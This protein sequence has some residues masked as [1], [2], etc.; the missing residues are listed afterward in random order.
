MATG[1]PIVLKPEDTKVRFDAE[2]AAETAF[3]F[4][5]SENV[6]SRFAERVEETANR[7]ELNAREFLFYDEAFHA[8][9]PPAAPETTNQIKEES[10]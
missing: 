10:L 7:V 1:D 8:F 9:R 6:F 5:R 3:N 2:A 4:G